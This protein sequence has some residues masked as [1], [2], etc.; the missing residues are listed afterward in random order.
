MYLSLWL[1]DLS[2]YK[3]VQRHNGPL[4]T[5]ISSIQH[6]LPTVCSYHFAVCS[7]SPAAGFNRP[8]PGEKWCVHQQIVS[9]AESSPEQ[10]PDVTLCSHSKQEDAVR[11]PPASLS[12]LSS[13]SCSA[14]L[15]A[16]MRCIHSHLWRG[17]GGIVGNQAGA[18]VGGTAVG[19]QEQGEV[20][21]AT[22]YHNDKTSQTDESTKFKE[23]I[24]IPCQ[25]RLGLIVTMWPICDEVWTN[26]FIICWF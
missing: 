16:H 18:R 6:A 23:T 14:A 4:E 12:S 13:L 5:W 10:P 2:W 8:Q 24:W 26:T 25:R 17:L 9:T 11:R 3:T 7:T 20:K 1:A 19:R 22:L 21:I 15:S